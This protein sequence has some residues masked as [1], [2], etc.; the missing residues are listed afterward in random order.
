METTINSQK[1]LNELTNIDIL[2]INGGGF[3]YDLGFF[4]REAVI[5]IA[6]GGNA[7]GNVAV[8]VDMGINYKPVH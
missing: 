5:Y 8:G 6:N 3:A 4:L 1:G 2:L 7:P